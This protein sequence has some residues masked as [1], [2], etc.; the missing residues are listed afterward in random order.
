M[1]PVI[2]YRLLYLF[3]VKGVVLLPGRAVPLP[4]R[5]VPDVV[6]LPS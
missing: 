3:P 2:R 1:F 6:P 5:A 4:S